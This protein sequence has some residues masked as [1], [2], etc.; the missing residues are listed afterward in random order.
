MRRRLEQAAKVACAYHC[1][2]F[3]K[4]LLTGEGAM[5]R[6]LLKFFVASALCWLAP[7]SLAEQLPANSPEL[8]QLRAMGYDVEQPDAGDA[9]TVVSNGS[10]KLTLIK[11]DDNVAVV[12]FFT[13]KSGLTSRQETELMKIVNKMNIDLSYQ[14]YLTQEHIAF[15]L[16][17]HGPYQRRTLASIIRLTEK[18]NDQ[19]DSYPGLLD[20]LN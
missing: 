1:L 9:F 6:N 8:Q 19:F 18:A 16:Y 13:R 17:A 7:A 5:I 14:I 3:L 15:A 2:S 10:I 4:R 11:G 12:R 20:L